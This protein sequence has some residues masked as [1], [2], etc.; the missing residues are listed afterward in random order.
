MGNKKRNAKKK[1]TIQNSV[2]HQ[3]EKN[4]VFTLANIMTVLAVLAAF[5]SAWYAKTTY[6]LAIE[7][8]NDEKK[9]VWLSKVDQKGE[10][11]EFTTNSDTIAM[12]TAYITF[13]EPFTDSNG[14]ILFPKF[15]LPTAVIKMN[16]EDYLE[17]QHLRKKGY[18]KVIES[19]IPFVLQSYYVVKGTS[20]SIQSLY[21]LRY[22]VTMGEEEGSFPTI[23]IQ[24]FW[25]DHH[26][27][28]NDSPKEALKTV[29]EN[30]NYKKEYWS[31]FAQ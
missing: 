3:K 5:L 23:E 19:Q 2:S 12:Q 31:K 25:F 13:P 21:H 10:E 14:E 26:L 17:S 18:A 7:Q 8:Q 15:K 30:G 16:L 1:S 28:I 22:L 20:Y 24:G 11:V 27:D 4:N 29:W 6:D 9:A